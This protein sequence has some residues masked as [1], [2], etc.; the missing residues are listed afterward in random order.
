[1][2]L[3]FVHW[4][5]TEKNNNE[6]RLSGRFGIVITIITCC[7]GLLVCSDGRANEIACA[8]V[9]DEEYTYQQ[10]CIDIETLE[11]VDCSKK[12]NAKICHLEIL[13]IY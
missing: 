3:R 10:K 8:S 11:E 9:L 5:I 4:V 6:V 13:E 1:M 2:I 7:V 12:E